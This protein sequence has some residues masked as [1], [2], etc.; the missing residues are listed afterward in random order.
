VPVIS[1]TDTASR[2]TGDSEPAMTQRSASALPFGGRHSQGYR[3]C[4]ESDMVYEAYKAHLLIWKALRDEATNSWFG[5]GSISWKIGSQTFVHR[6]EGPHGA[7]EA[8]AT[9]QWK[10]IAEKWVDTKA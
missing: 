10:E 1:E 5:S 7:S 6:L 3:D 9:A 4:Y 8:I 2:E